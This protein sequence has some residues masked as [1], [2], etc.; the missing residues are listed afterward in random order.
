MDVIYDFD[1]LAELLGG[2]KILCPLN[3]KMLAFISGSNCFF[4]SWLRTVKFFDKLVPKIWSKMNEKNE[5]YAEIISIDYLY[6]LILFIN[7]KNN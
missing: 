4:K 3:A 1:P 7:I 5:P 2:H 6:I